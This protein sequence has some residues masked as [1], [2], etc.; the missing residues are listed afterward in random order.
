MIR[1]RQRGVDLYPRH[2]TSDAVPRSPHIG[3]KSLP[4][5]AGMALCVVK[6]R[7]VPACILVGH[8]T[9]RASELP[10][11]KTAAFHELQGLEAGHLQRR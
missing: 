11:L 8:M 3:M 9:R 5:M 4:V 1:K 7:I 2:V 6:S 10:G